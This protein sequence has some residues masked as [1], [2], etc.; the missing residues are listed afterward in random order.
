[1]NTDTK[2]VVVLAIAVS[3]AAGSIGLSQAD[4]Q[5]RPQWS[6]PETMENRQVLPEGTGGAGLRSR[7]VSYAVGLGVRCQHCHVGAEGLDF[8][9]FDFASDERD[10]KSIARGMIRMTAAL[11]EVQLPA[12]EQL[13]GPRVTCFTCH[14]GA[15]TPATRPDPESMQ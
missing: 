9:E 14:R 6:W 8:S 11:N 15:I 10:A 7:M 5:E 4:A 1:M 3:A 13:E 2:S 12:I